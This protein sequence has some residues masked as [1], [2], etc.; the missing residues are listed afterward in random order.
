M[1]SLQLAKMIDATL[2]NTNA[3]YEQI[4]SLCKDAAANDVWSVCVNPVHVKR[5]RQFLSATS[6]KV[7]SVLGFPLGANRTATKV[8]EARQ[9]LEDGADEI[10]MVMNVG[11]FLSGDVKTV[12]QDITAVVGAADGKV[13]KVIIE[14]TFLDRETIAQ[15]A[16]VVSRAGADF[17]KTQTGW[18]QT[19]NTTPEDIRL[20]KSAIAPQ[21]KIKASGGTRSWEA[22]SGLLG[23]GAARFG[24]RIQDVPHILADCVNI[25]A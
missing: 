12:E 8:F 6:L 10:D 24:V 11:A 18:A 22:I 1:E 23:A 4:E 21:V 7:C 9:A 16:Q 20:I 15:A 17:V 3:T 25:A 14:I 5:A 13:V 19:R 2:L